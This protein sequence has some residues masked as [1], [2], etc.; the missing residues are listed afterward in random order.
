MKDLEIQWPLQ[1]IKSEDLI[2][3]I[4]RRVGDNPDREGVLDTPR[5]VVKSWKEL[6]AGYG[7]DYRTILGTTFEKGTYDQIIIC[8]DIE[9]YSTC[10][11]HMIPFMGKVHIG[12]IPDNRVVGLSKLARLAEVFARRLQI[13]EKMTEQ[14]KDAMVE[15]L[16]PKGVMVVVEAKHLCMCGRG[17]GKQ[18]STMITSSIYGMFMQD[19]ARSEFMRLVK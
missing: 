15:V 3:E 5:R 8:K 14:I 1:M 19:E 9:F 17:V 4:I 6:F 2:R 10:E 7:M 13:Q 11:H 18:N 16:K 12:Y